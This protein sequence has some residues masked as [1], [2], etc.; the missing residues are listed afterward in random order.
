MTL[1]FDGK[2]ISM[3]NI[4]DAYFYAINSIHKLFKILLQNFAYD[5][6]AL[7]PSN[8]DDDFGDNC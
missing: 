5:K 6:S 1:E 4:A 2:W 8:I 7:W 3:C